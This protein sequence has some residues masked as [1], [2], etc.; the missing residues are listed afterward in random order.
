MT[1]YME[2]VS[3]S[4][5]FRTLLGTVLKIAKMGNLGKTEK[6]IMLRRGFEPSATVKSNFEVPHSAY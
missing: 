6:N 2:K 4:E 3:S 1:D 5:L